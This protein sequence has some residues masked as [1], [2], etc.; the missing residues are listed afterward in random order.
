MS[1]AQAV[2]PA[3][4]SEETVREWLETELG[5]VTML[6]RQARW[7]PVWFAD[8]ERDG[9]VLRL[10]VRGPRVDN[11]PQFPLDHEMR[12]QRLL[13]E[14]GLP[15]ARVH[16]S[17]AD[18]SFYVMDRVDGVPD[19]AASTDA[20]RRSIVDQYL[21]VLARIH[22]LD[23]RPFAA[24]GI[25][26]APDPTLSWQP[27][28]AAFERA[29]RVTKARPDPLMEWGLGW[30]RRNPLAN[31]SGRE[32]P[33]VWDSGQFLHANGRLTALMDLELG[34]VGDPMMDLAGWRM[35]DTIIP[36]GDFTELYAR[37]EEYRGE[38][39]DLEAIRW[40]H[41]AFTLTN[42]LSFHAALAAPP[43]GSAYMTNLQWCAETNVM[44]VE[45]YAEDHGIELEQLALPAYEGSPVAPAF[46]HLVA[47]L[48][49]FPATDD[50]T[51]YEARMAFRLARHLE[52]FDQIGRIV[53]DADLDDLARLLGRRPAS[54][55]EGERALEEFVLADDGAR[56]TELLLLFNRRT[57]RAQML[58]GPAGSAMARHHKVQ[59]F[60]KEPAAFR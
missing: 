25:T 46:A 40:H 48:R 42:Q 33:V 35:R 23:V 53:T 16:G 43:P 39:V 8:V 7:R 34:H 3:G 28:I 10:C 2:R 6:A 19:F 47:S 1:T 12:F 20:E 50:I 18:P 49:N 57:Q 11:E 38:P 14:A 29:Y 60:P 4:P 59:P 44:V 37:Y 17:S 27:G 55:E 21:Q 51:A 30:L 26:R 45:A 13:Q 24:A 41:F 32:S 52:R 9:G 58:L 31:P 36:Y 22:R 56:D 5:P 15:V 54:W